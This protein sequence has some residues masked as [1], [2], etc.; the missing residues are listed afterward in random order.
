MERIAGSMLNIAF[1]PIQV[2]CEVE[3][4][5]LVRNPKPMAIMIDPRS[6]RGV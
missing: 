2:E 6:I 5:K 1:H 3:G 4:V